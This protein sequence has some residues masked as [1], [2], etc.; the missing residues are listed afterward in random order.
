MMMIEEKIE[1][2]I[3]M[4]FLF[5]IMLL[6]ISLTSKEFVGVSLLFYIAF[7]KD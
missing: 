5:L 6:G 3:K 7:V 1:K 2:F 4:L